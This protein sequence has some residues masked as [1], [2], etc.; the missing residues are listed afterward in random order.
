MIKGIEKTDC[1]F[2]S[3][4]LFGL[5]IFIVLILN[6]RLSNDDIKSIV[7]IVLNTSSITMGFFAT[8]F[9]FIFGFKDNYIHKEIMKSNLKKRQ[10][11]FLNI[12]IIVMG[13]LQII[14]SFVVMLLLTIKNTQSKDIAKYLN[15]F[16]HFNL[17][18]VSF[19][20]V[21]T[22]FFVFFLF[23]A[24]YL[25]L[26]LSMIFKSNDNNNLPQKKMPSIK[27]NKV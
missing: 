7:E 9:T 19:H 10:Y 4:F 26:I 13:F 21:L 6:V 27:N 22:L 12:C 3:Y 23:F 2:G 20:F 14:V 17:T 11:K 18:Q 16:L 24:T 25:L 5:I 15:N 8:V 1:I